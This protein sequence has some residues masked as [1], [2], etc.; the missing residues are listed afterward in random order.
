VR[1]VG[2]EEGER[3]NPTSTRYWSARRTVL[4]TGKGRIPTTRSSHLTTDLLHRWYLS[5]SSS[6]PLSQLIPLTNNTLV[7]PSHQQQH[8]GLS[9]SQPQLGSSD[10]ALTTP[11]GFWMWHP[12]LG[13]AWW[14]VRLGVAAKVES[15]RIGSGNERCILLW[16]M[17]CVFAR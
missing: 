4:Q 5:L 12:V 8:P 1:D 3:Y 6:P 15:G 13:P 2:V 16:A 9:L 14:C 7:R 11:T 10:L 17:K